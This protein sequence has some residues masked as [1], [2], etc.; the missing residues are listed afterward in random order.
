MTN[1]TRKL[2]ALLKQCNADAELKKRVYSSL[3]KLGLDKNPPIS[4][5]KSLHITPANIHTL[6]VK[7]AKIADDATQLQVVTSTT[8]S[9]GQLFTVSQIINSHGWKLLHTDAA[10]HN[11]S[12]FK[13]K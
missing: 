4:I 6:D 8:L 3:K 2:Q 13:R 9:H 7:L 11:I 12:F 1:T 10:E 5:R